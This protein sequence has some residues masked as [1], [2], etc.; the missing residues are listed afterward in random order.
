MDLSMRAM[1]RCMDI[2]GAVSAQAN[3]LT[4][5]PA[6]PPPRSLRDE[7]DFIRSTLCRPEKPR[8][9][10]RLRVTSVADREISLSWEDQADNEDGF[11]IR[12]RGK[13]AEVSDHTGTKSVGPNEVSATL[14]GLRSGYEYTIGIVAFNAGGESGQTG[15]ARAT[16]PARTISVALEGV[17]SSAVFLVTG[18]GFTPNSIVVIRAISPLGGQVSFVE[19]AGGDGRFVARRS[20]PCVTGV[21][22]TFTAFEDADPEGTFA[23][24][25]VTTCP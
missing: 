18:A 7:L 2:T 25:I 8:G 23:N 13:R 1:A 11:R 5:R 14:T 3:I 6:V 12:F 15:P 24:T 19:A 16:T 20:I 17:G 4:V 22:L 9:P 21:Q 10:N